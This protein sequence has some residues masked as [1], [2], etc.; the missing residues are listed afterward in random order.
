M[1]LALAD[2][3]QVLYEVLAEIYNF[4]LCNEVQSEILNVTP[5][6]SNQPPEGCVHK[7]EVKTQQ[8]IY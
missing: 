8:H 7:T 4:Q 6:S 1:T 3:R 5:S 2:I